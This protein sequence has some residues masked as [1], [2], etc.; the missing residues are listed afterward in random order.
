[1][2]ACRLKRRPYTHTCVANY[3]G[4]TRTHVAAAAAAYAA[5]SAQVLLFSSSSA[6]VARVALPLPGTSPPP[7]PPSPHLSGPRRNAGRSDGRMAAW[8]ALTLAK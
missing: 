1:M 2:N 8:L 4:A 6:T 5:G 3:N 7:P